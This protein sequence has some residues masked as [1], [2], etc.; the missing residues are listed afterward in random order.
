MRKTS[1]FKSTEP[2]LGFDDVLIVPNGSNVSSRKEVDLTTQLPKGFNLKIPVFS[3]AM[4]TIASPALGAVLFQYGAGFLLPKTFTLESYKFWFEL[5][6]DNDLYN[7]Q[8]KGVLGVAVGIERSIED[9]KELLEIGYD[10]I[11]IEMPVIRMKGIENWIYKV[12]NLVNKYNKLLAVGNVVSPEDIAWLEQII[13]YGIHIVKV[14]YGFGGTATS[15][16]ISGLGVPTLQ[17]VIDLNNSG[18]PYLILGDGGI[19]NPGDLAKLLVAGACGGIC[20]TLFAG[21]NEAA[22]KEI[23]KNEKKL[24]QFRGMASIAAKRDRGDQELLFQQGSNGLVPWRGPVKIQLKRIKEGL[25]IA[26]ATTGCKTLDEFK[27]KAQFIKVSHGV[28][29][30]IQNIEI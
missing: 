19:R 29:G 21:T 6:I 1:L 3:A 23:I 18:C 27:D 4:D 9:I 12:A 7:P 5:F 20:G 11:L 16:W 25:Q 17:A 24:K 2:A 15:R 10:C 13:P 8:E 22:G 30:L 28:P 14:G 26:A